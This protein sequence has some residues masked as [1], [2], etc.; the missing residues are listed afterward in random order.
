MWTERGKKQ[1]QRAKGNFETAVQA[2]PAKERPL[3]DAADGFGR[4]DPLNRKAERITIADVLGKRPQSIEV[5]LKRDTLK[6]QGA[7][8]SAV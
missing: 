3:E 5:A 7:S 6:S 2:V 4:L 8:P 1:E